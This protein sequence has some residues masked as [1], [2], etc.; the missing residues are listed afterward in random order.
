MFGP[1]SFAFR[2]FFLMPP[3]R[4]VCPFRARNNCF[5]SLFEKNTKKREKK[6]EQKKRKKKLFQKLFVEEHP[7]YNQ[8]N[9]QI[10]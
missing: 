10:N 1:K 9:N 2:I 5:G 7:R 8:S 3:N 6:F 4:I